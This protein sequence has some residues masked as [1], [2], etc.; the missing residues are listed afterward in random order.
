MI[1]V[2]DVFKEQRTDLQNTHAHCSVYTEY[3]LGWDVA[4]CTLVPV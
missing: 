4:H 2:N 1:D 3:G